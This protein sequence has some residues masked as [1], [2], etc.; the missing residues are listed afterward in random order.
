MQDDI[1][2]E[3]KETTNSLREAA[4]KQREI[5]SR[6]VAESRGLNHKEN[7]EYNLLAA[8][9]NTLHHKLDTIAKQVKTPEPD[10]QCNN[11]CRCQTYAP[12]S[13]VENRLAFDTAR[14]EWQRRQHRR[15]MIIMA[16]GI[17]VIFTAL[18]TGFTALVLNFID[19]VNDTSGDNGEI[20]YNEDTRKSADNEFYL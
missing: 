18:F 15:I 1:I 8:N 16:I 6:A 19:A 17:V 11:C 9:I 14:H 20:Q 4:I 12:A 3:Y 2:E 13:D 7:T 10:K 5:I